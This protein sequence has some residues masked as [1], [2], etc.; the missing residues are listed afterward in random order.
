[1]HGQ[2]YEFSNGLYRPGYEDGV[3]VTVGSDVYTHDPLGKYD[4]LGNVS[5]PYIVAAADG[6]VR[7]IVEQYDTSCATV[8]NGQITSCCWQWNNYII[9]EHP[10][11]E[12]TQY[13]HIQHNSADD[14]GIEVGDWVTQGTAIG[15][16]GTVGCSTGDHLHLEVSRPFDVT[17][18][19]DT[20]GG[21]LN[22]KGEMLIP[23]IGGISPDNPWMTDGDS[24]TAGP[25]ND[26]CATNVTAN[27]SVGNGGFHIARADENITT[28][29]STDVVFS[30]GSTTQYR[31]G[32]YIRLIPNFHAQAGTKFSALIKTCNQQN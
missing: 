23:V 4:L 2:H 25:C 17:D 27:T 15:I 9:L 19:F 1:M 26:N 13:T 24:H 29:S 7:W 21:F 11:G 28:S 6:W 12:W 18:P 14:L 16:E 20:I 30:N 3:V 32:N 22:N 10:N 31:A 8:V 5:S